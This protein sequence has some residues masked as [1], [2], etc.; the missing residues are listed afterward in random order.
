EGQPEPPPEQQLELN[1]YWN[2]PN[3]QL[4]ANFFARISG[5]ASASA[6][7]LH[8]HGGEGIVLLLDA[9]R[10]LLQHDRFKDNIRRV[11]EQ[12]RDPRDPR[13]TYFVGTHLLQSGGG[14]EVHF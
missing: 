4:P 12:V 3:Q 14:G 7:P 6:A 10:G 1:E 13:S 8:L 9:Q 2:I 11:A 5:R